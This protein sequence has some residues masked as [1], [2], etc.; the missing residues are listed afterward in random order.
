[1]FARVPS[2]EGQNTNLVH[3][4]SGMMILEEWHTSGQA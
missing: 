3:F 2:P 1:M 4:L